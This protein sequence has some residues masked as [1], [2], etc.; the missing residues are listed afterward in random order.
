MS[1]NGHASERP[2]VPGSRTETLP[3]RRRVL[4][5]SQTLPSDEV[6]RGVWYR[7]HL[8]RV[9][10]TS[11]P[12]VSQAP[13]KKTYHIPV[14]NR[15]RSKC[16]TPV[17]WGLSSPYKGRDT[18]GPVGGSGGDDGLPSLWTSDPTRTGPFRFDQGSRV[19]I[20]RIWGLKEGRSVH[21]EE[22][23]RKR[24]L[25]TC[26]VERARPS[27]RGLGVPLKNS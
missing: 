26:S 14:T 18:D 2:A 11:L 23:K 16:L 22:T 3:G 20:Q 1:S 7:R 25:G 27:S 5:S 4:S 17:S 6:P 21:L 8:S 10:W 19:S 24:S 15:P 12:V 9:T 13:V